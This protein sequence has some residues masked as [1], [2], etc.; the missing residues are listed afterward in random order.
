MGIFW[1]FFRCQYHNYVCGC[2]L[3][4][5]LAKKA[6][7]EVRQKAKEQVASFPG[8]PPLEMPGNEAK[9]RGIV[10]A[11]YLGKTRSTY[12]TLVIPAL[13]IFSPCNNGTFILFHGHLY[14][15]ES[16]QT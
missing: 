12:G 15:G 8:V 5:V 11:V 1:W 4:L 9:E 3:S 7:R 2:S 6:K 14:M 10:T 16:L 13:H